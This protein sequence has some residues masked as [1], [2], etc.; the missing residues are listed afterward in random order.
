MEGKS[1]KYSVKPVVASIIVASGPQN[2]PT[3]ALRVLLARLEPCPGLLMSSETVNSW[4]DLT[5]TA[6]SPHHVF[7]G[8]FPK[9]GTSNSIANLY[10]VDSITAMRRPFQ[11]H[12][13]KES[14]CG[15]RIFGHCDM[16]VHCTQDDWLEYMKH[17]EPAS[18]IAYRSIQDS[19]TSPVRLENSDMQ[20]YCL[21]V[22]FEDLEL[23]ICPVQ[24]EHCPEAF[25]SH[26]VVGRLGLHRTD[27]DCPVSLKSDQGIRFEATKCTQI[28][29]SLKDSTKRE[30]WLNI[31]DPVALV[32]FHIVCPRT[33][34]SGW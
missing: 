14:E 13:V 17:R 1:I 2:Q 16:V 19:F 21:P 7:Q 34:L 28:Q 11:A 23:Q 20:Q 4:Q 32:P 31:I 26:D 29:V 30:L 18:L 8:I 9:L 12:V 10:H 22:Y 3:K 5:V 24:D 15:R 6:K 27:L 25:I 33:K